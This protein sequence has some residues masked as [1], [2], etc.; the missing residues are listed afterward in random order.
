MSLFMILQTLS[1][2]LKV[3][4][5]TFT[6]TVLHWR[7]VYL[8]GS[9]A[10]QRHHILTIVQCYSYNVNIHIL[11]KF[12]PKW[13][14]GE[15]F[16]VSLSSQTRA[17]MWREWHLTNSTGRTLYYPNCKPSLNNCLG[18]EI[19]RPIHALGLPNRDLS[20]GDCHRLYNAFLEFL[21]MYLHD[22]KKP[23]TLI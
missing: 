23:D 10:L 13:Q 5:P 18:T 11:P 17:S 3:N 9:A 15:E 1:I 22:Y 14:L 16:G 7:L 20:N 8:P 4:A 12:K 6:G 19:V 2:P 21:C